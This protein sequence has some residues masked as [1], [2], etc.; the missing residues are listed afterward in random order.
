MMLLNLAAL[1]LLSSPL[2]T[3]PIS[4]KRTFVTGLK[5]AYKV[6]A[7]LHVE[8]RQRG[9][10]TFL[11]EDAEIYYGF[12]TTV[13]GVTG[14]IASV[15]YERPTFTEA[16]SEAADE[17]PHKNV[18]QLDQV[19]LL[20][21]SPINEILDHKSITK[22]KKATEDSGSE[23][24]RSKTK[25]AQGSIGDF[26]GPFIQDMERLSLFVGPLDSSMDFAPRLD[27]QPV[28]VGDTWKRTVGFQ[29]QKLKYKSGKTEVQRLDITYSYSGPGT[30]NGKPVLKVHADL[31]LNT[32]LGAYLNDL[33]GL[34]ADDTKIKSIPLKLVSKL[35]FFLDPKTLQTLK[36]VCTSEGS[37]QILTTLVPEPLEEEKLKG[38]STLTLMSN[39]IVKAKPKS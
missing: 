39:K 18:E 15:R 35:D 38:S 16:A 25:H 13:L 4:L 21:V 10:K 17:Q 33:V 27:L 3:G 24:I 26:I 31:N 32:D 37:F 36:G 30:L 6:D 22:P 7:Q 20:Q 34:T 12:T 14:G 5:S 1:A 11:P 23:R 29:P 2:Q 9:L 19:D 28:K 8:R